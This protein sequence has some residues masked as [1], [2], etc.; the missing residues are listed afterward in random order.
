[1]SVRPSRSGN[2]TRSGNQNLVEAFQPPNSCAAASVAVA[3]RKVFG[4]ASLNE[5]VTGFD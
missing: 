5:S 3:S 4:L 1:M 2:Q